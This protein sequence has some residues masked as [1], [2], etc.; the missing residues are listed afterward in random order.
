MSVSS[1]CV[2]N[3]VV[4]SFDPD[5]ALECECKAWLERVVK[6]PP[7]Q[8]QLKQA[9]QVGYAITTYGF[10]R[11]IDDREA[12]RLKPTTPLQEAIDQA[13]M[14]VQAAMDQQLTAL[15]MEKDQEVR[16]RQLDLDHLNTKLRHLQDEHDALGTYI[17]AQRESYERDKHREIDGLKQTMDA[18]VAVK[19][20]EIAA[21]KTTVRDFKEEKQREVQRIQDIMR[22]ST[23]S[24]QVMV[25]QRD[26]QIK[27]MQQSLATEMNELRVM[28]HNKDA[29]IRAL[30]DRLISSSQQEEIQKLH[31]AI[32]ERDIMIAQIK[33][34]NTFKGIKGE[35][36][37]VDILKRHF[38]SH[39]IRHV[40]QVGGGHE[41]DIHMFNQNDELVVVEVKNKDTITNLDVNKSLNDIANLKCKYGD[42]FKAYVF[43]S[44]RNYNIPKKGTCFEIVN[45]VPVV[46]HGTDV[47][48]DP[49]AEKQVVDMVNISLKL[50]T[51]LRAGL[52]DMSKVTTFVND[53]NYTVTKNRAPMSSL[54]NS[55]TSILNTLKALTEN[56]DR[57]GELIDRFMEENN[58]GT[59]VDKAKSE[60]HC[61]HCP[62]VYKSSTT[63]DRHITT[64]H[65]T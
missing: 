57:L 32:K 65:N 21:L 19:D 39:D 6:E 26:Q 27:D 23:N 4:F 18:R 13:R 8:E 34:N 56:N 45:D 11:I 36:D 30:S 58:I 37:V 25:V 59:I 38:K 24:L 28:L 9:I 42:R 62:K 50:A 12:K 51:V 5:S 46:W 64:V 2:L 54:Y 55:A 7:P 44:L 52:T 16:Q 53:L 41:S 61:P 35:L 14:Q 29:E 47:E 17:K 40:G 49:H 63:L 43:V 3:N 31:D 33:V 10:D 20:D 15:R 48:T 22:D 60:Y 1:V